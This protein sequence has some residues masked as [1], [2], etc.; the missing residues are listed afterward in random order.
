MAE[1]LMHAVQYS[2]YG[3]GASGLEHVEIPLPYLNK[4]EVLVKV[5]AASINPVDW[6]FQKGLLRP[7]FPFKFPY[8]PCGDVA[9]EIV[10]VGSSVKNFK[11]GDKVVAIV[12]PRAFTRTL[13][14]KLDGSDRPINI[15]VTA[16][17]GGVGHFVVQIAKL[18]NAHVTAT[19]GARNLKFVKS[20]GA[21]EVIDYKTPEGAALKSPSGRKYDV[22]IHCALGIPWSTFEPN[23]SPD[24]KVVDVTPGLSTLTTHAL[25]KLTF[26]KKQLVPLLLS[27]DI[28]DL[29]FLVNLVKEGK[30]WPFPVEAVPFGSLGYA[31]C[32]RGGK[33]A[34]R[35]LWVEDGGGGGCSVPGDCHRRQGGKGGK[36]ACN[37]KK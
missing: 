4:E 6:K 31:A 17:S 33:D 14:M 26:S 9:G 30:C 19:C 13:G 24:G 34:V 32:D 12:D 5:E 36:D 35:R 10:E 1:K 7:V 8:I 29:D 37:A 11:A 22:V 20:L 25:Q 16:A 21:D 27:L 23:L 3:G 18:G 28:K 2:S 15:L